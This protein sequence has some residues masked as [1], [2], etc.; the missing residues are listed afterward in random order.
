MPFESPSLHVSN[1]L[2]D[3]YMGRDATKRTLRR[4]NQN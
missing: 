1:Y 4:E 3:T 2:V